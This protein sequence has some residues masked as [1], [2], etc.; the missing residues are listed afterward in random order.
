DERQKKE[1]WPDSDLPE[2][3]RIA[4]SN[5]LEDYLN[6]KSLYRLIEPTMRL[7]VLNG[8]L[9]WCC[10]RLRGGIYAGFDLAHKKTKTGCF[11]RDDLI[12][13][14]ATL[15][16]DCWE[17]GDLVGL[18]DAERDAYNNV[19]KEQNINIYQRFVYKNC[20][21]LEV[22]NLFKKTGCSLL[23]KLVHSGKIVAY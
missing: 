20:P 14:D 8:D 7:L 23:K 1:F 4:D 19:V 12:A 17:E 22:D 10:G 5:P 2:G 13:L 18:T 16:R 15:Q 9:Q 6:R 11:T 21:T 3:V